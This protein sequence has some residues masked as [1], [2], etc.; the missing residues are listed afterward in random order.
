[1]ETNGNSNGKFLGGQ[2]EVSRS[3]L[4]LA[5]MAMRH[6]YPLTDEIR[7]NI[8][9]TAHGI[10]MAS[11]DPR[12]Q[13]LAAKVLLTADS[14]NVRR[15]T[16]RVAERQTDVHEAT[17]LLREAMKTPEARK[18]MAGLSDEICKPIIDVKPASSS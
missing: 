2:G 7:L 3:D 14:V 8:V 1:M 12:W 15:E 5:D 13:L 16:N 9:S 6:E 17:V 4:R 18:L 11:E 10:L